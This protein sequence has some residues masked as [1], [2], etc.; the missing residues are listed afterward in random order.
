M[1]DLLKD[2]IAD[3]KAVR[4]TALA[5]A[6][7]ALEE[8]F[9]PRIQSMLSNKIQSEM[10]P[11]EG[12]SADVVAGEDEPSGEPVQP[13]IPEGEDEEPE[14]AVEPEIGEEEP[15]VAQ[16]EIPGEE[17]PL[18]AQDEVPG[19]EFSEPEAE[20]PGEEV[21]LAAQDEIPGDEW[22]EEEPEAIEG[23][24]EINGVKYAPVVSEEDEDALEPR[25]SGE[26]VD[27]EE[28]SIDDLDLEAILK[29]LEDEAD[30]AEVD[31]NYEEGEVGDGLSSKEAT[32]ADEAELAE[33]D[34]SSDIGD[35]DNKVA[36]AAADSSDVG[37]GSEEPA[38]ADAP[39]AG[40]ENP[41]DEEVDDLVE[42][43]GVRYQKV[44]EQDE[45]EARNGDLEK[46][47]STEEDIDLEEILKALSEQD[48]E[49]EE[50]AADQ[51]ESLSSDLAEH[52]KV[53]KYLR[54]KLN[55]VNL[56]NAKL[57]FTNK[58]FRA[59]GLTN[60][61]KLKVVETFDR[62]TNLREVKLVFA[63]LAESFGSR[64]ASP[65][66]QIKEKKGSASKAVASTKPKSTPKVIGEGFD[67][68][69]RFQKLA[70]IL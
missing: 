41:E 13:G 62:A 60:E 52:R 66:K 57:L 68:K 51:V 70:N 5:N 2:A 39:A 4:E 34:V 54:S 3:A 27:V 45:W 8:A 16:D 10:E 50:A 6:K 11:D 1:D 53:V 61:Q 17:V 59:H 48:D 22:S 7:I 33:N 64:T 40:H 58:L 20:V 38:S 30:E 49:E 25:R 63:T 28:E 19:D 69:Q 46:N 67:M 31:E 44:K 43:N 29:E 65:S 36:D 14:I 35:G 47:E 37:Q 12:D 32:T 55:E 18:A 26:Y 56:L 21:P 24:I 23:V 42:V 9:T 15:I